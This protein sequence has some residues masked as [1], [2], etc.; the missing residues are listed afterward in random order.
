M[1]IKALRER[2]GILI[3]TLI[4]IPKKIRKIDYRWTAEIGV[5]LSNGVMDGIL[6][7]STQKEIEISPSARAGVTAAK[8]GNW[9]TRQNSSGESRSAQLD[10]QLFRG[11][12]LNAL[13]LP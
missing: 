2:C 4:F 13:V 9:R 8:Y 10:V 6:F 11:I 7:G 5:A 12:A 3:T 1:S